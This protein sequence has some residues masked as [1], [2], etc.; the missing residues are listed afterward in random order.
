MATLRDIR[1]RIASVKN[2]RQITNAMKMVSAAKLRRA[3]ESATSARPYQQTLTL[4]LRRVAA[5]AGDIEHPLLTS[6]DVVKKVLVIV[7]TS[8]RGLCGGFN[9]TLNR[10]T[11]DF[12]KKQRVAHHDVALRMYGRKSK[13]YFKS[14]GFAN[15]IARTD[16]IRAQFADEAAVLA[17]ELTTEFEAGGFDEAWI[18]F[19]QFKSVIAQVPTFNRVLPLS[20]ETV[21]AAGEAASADGAS[22]DYLYEPSGESLLGALLPMYLRT[23]LLQAFLE[24]EAGEQAARM[25]AMDNATRNASDLISALT[26]EYNR[27]RQAAITKELIEIVSGAEAL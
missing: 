4:T 9:G 8:D 15:S 5:G 27:G 19:N 22:A 20:I 21:V 17:G 12:I 10:R 16:L 24:T 26:L 18:A 6:R 13:D 3:T 23:L 11:E 25:T 14:R 1:T 7:V 2:T